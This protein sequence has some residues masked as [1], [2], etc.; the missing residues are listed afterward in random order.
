MCHPV[1]GVPP[2]G[3]ALASNERLWISTR[4][5]EKVAPLTRQRRG[6]R[7]HRAQERPRLRLHRRLPRLGRAL[8]PRRR[9]CR[10]RRGRHRLR[11]RRPAPARTR[12]LCRRCRRGRG[13]RAA[14][15]RQAFLCLLAQLLLRAQL[16][17]QLVVHAHQRLGVVDV[18][19]EL[20]SHGLIRGLL[21]LQLVLRPHQLRPKVPL[22]CGQTRRSQPIRRACQRTGQ[23]SAGWRCFPADTV[24]AAGR[25]RRE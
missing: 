19:L 16:M 8:R 3:N 24:A 18:P 17:A 10:G 6:V 5:Y 25:R 14:A 20:R 7:G 21:S 15:F 1:R 11:L 23:S 2:V 12:L 4:K 22:P 9:R 13:G